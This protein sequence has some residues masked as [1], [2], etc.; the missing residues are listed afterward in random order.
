MQ[1]T[2]TSVLHEAVD[3]AWRIGYLNAGS[4]IKP[5]LLRRQTMVKP[6]YKCKGCGKEFNG[7]RRLGDHYAEFPDHRPAGRP[8]TASTGSPVRMN[9]RKLSATDLIQAAVDKMA[10]EINAKRQMLA[11][12]EK[13]KAEITALENQRTAL[14][15]MLVPEKTI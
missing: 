4:A 7:G 2:V 10:V 9:V 12:V 3:A 6:I 15:K 11:D 5:P 13:I 14:Q 1:L 8:R